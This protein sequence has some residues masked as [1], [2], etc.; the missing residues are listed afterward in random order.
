MDDGAGEPVT[1]IEGMT[2]S[3]RTRQ[4]IEEAA[5]EAVVSVYDAVHAL[6]D[7]YG[8]LAS[9]HPDVAAGATPIR[10]MHGGVGLMPGE[11]VGNRPDG[12]SPAGSVTQI[13]LGEPRPL[14]DYGCFLPGDLDLFADPAD[15]H[16]QPDV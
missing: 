15:G 16:P 14:Q 3:I 6:L 4:D 13:V 1:P 12:L 11:R 7:R 9:D 10:H 5:A 8:E 2:I